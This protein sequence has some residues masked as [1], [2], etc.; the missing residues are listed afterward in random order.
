MTQFRSDIVQ[1]DGRADLA[2]M[3]G[4]FDMTV[5]MGDGETRMVGKWVA[6]YR[7]EDGDWRCASDC[8]NLDAPMPA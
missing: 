6:T 7:K 1:V 4:T 5:E 3:R 2:S 8:W